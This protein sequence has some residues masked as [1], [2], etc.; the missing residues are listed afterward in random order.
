MTKFFAI[1]WLLYIIITQNTIICIANFMPF[2]K[3]YTFLL[4]FFTKCR[5]TKKHT[6]SPTPK[7]RIKLILQQQKKRI[8]GFPIR[9]F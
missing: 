3:I 9:E 6:P 1:K 8:N 7:R 2:F 4:G 5:A